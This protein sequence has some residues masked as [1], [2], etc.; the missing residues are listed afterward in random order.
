MRGAFILLVAAAHATLDWIS[1][2]NSTPR[3]LIDSYGR[4]RIL[5]GVNVGV[6][7]W[8]PHGRPIDPALYESACPRDND[9][10]TGKVWEH[11]ILKAGIQFGSAMALRTCTPR[12]DFA[13]AV[14]CTK[15]LLGR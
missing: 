4:E 11:G 3:V 12:M 2:S 6:E 7:W 8:S 14:V 5:R 15:M 10:V 1:V 13:M 9:T